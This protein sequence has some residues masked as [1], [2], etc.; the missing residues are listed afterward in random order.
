MRGLVWEFVW[1]KRSYKPSATH[2]Y[3]SVG[4]SRACPAEDATIGA[5]CQSCCI[6]GGRQSALLGCC[7]WPQ[8]RYGTSPSSSRTLIVA[9]PSGVRVLLV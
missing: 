3:Y 5:C 7:M 9:V 6:I 2:D 8:A 1:S 4:S